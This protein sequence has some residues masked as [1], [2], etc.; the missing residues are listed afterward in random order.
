MVRFLCPVIMAAVWIGLLAAPAHAGQPPPEGWV[1]EAIPAAPEGFPVRVGE[2]VTPMTYK[3]FTSQLRVPVVVGDDAEVVARINEALGY[4]KLVGETIDETV[5]NYANCGCGM[6][7]VDFRVNLQRGNILDIT[8]VLEGM[9]AYPDWHYLGFTFDVRTGTLME[10]ADLFC[11]CCLDELATLADAKL[12]ANIA[13][14][15][16][17]TDERYRQEQGRMLTN[18]HFT[19]EHLEHFTVTEAGVEFE[20]EFDFAH[21]IEALEPDETVVFTFKELG[22]Y[23]RDRGLM[24]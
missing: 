19:T 5:A 7:A 4:G 11:G 3:G 15:L 23:L 8:V 1:Q 9:G 14:A 18:H 24:R 17:E 6:V 12:Q 21:A 13:A 2:V 10:A 22:K 20:Y 16:A